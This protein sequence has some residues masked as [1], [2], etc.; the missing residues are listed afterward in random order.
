MAR[1]RATA[2]A[3]LATDA[4]LKKAAAAYKAAEKDAATAVS[5]LKASVQ[6]ARQSGEYLIECLRRVPHGDKQDWLEVHYCRPY[7][8][9]YRQ[10]AK[11]IQIARPDRKL[12]EENLPSGASINRAAS[13]AGKLVRGGLPQPA[14]EQA[15]EA[16][17]QEAGQQPQQGPQPPGA[18]QVPEP[19]EAEAGG[20]E[21]DAA[22]NV[23]PAGQPAAQQAAAPT[24]E[25][26]A[27]LEERVKAKLAEA[28]VKVKAGT[29]W[30][31][32]LAVGFT[33]EEVA[34]KLLT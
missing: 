1:K 16:G 23:V 4:L 29:A 32:L 11:C 6:K 19:A 2:L 30:A 5:K 7:G 3:K 21:V 18:G 22:G 24:P 13:I 17:E 8:I 9:S 33:H 31:V 14:A 27:A 25:Q 34:A 15:A 28:G 12:L 26:E 20:L 10:A